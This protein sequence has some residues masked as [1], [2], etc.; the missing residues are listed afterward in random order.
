MQT[1]AYI[2][3]SDPQPRCSAGSR[4]TPAVN[5]YEQEF[6]AIPSAEDEAKNGGKKGSDNF[7]LGKQCCT[8]MQLSC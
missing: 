6:D 8:G 7:L 2:S 4:E 1:F 3:L 5:G